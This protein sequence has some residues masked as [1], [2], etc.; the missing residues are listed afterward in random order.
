[1][2]ETQSFL[3]EHHGIRGGVV[4]LHETWL[5]IIA[6]HGYP[7]DVREL[8]GEGVAA[9][10]LLGASLKDRPKISIQAQGDG[11]LRLLVIQCSSQLSVRGMAQIREDAPRA[12]L[13]GNGRLS[14]N[15]D[16]G[17]TNGFFQGI[18]PL[19]GSR[20]SDCLEA[21]F[22]Q[23][24]QLPT[25]FF[26]FSTPRNATGIVLQ[27]LPGSEDYSEFENASMLASKLTGSELFDTACE[28]LLPRTFA[29]YTIRLFKP[30]RVTHDCRC[31][32]E[33]LAGI[34]RMLGSEELESLIAE[35]G[36]VELTCEFCNRNFQYS[37]ED[38]SAILRGESPQACLH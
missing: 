28:D 38:V 23:S 16:T 19:A 20:L 33:H 2:N 24:E 1:M 32:P 4:R 31:T 13:L 14:V 35:L 15:I 34:A 30:R 29:G 11:A 17:R 3:F 18:V 22:D 36:H 6:Q 27:M 37:K 21:Y 25:R 12:P 10:V 26:L 8:L 5:Q 9:T 7:G